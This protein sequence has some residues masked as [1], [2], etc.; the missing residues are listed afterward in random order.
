MQAGADLVPVNVV[1]V[2]IVIGPELVQTGS[3]G[4]DIQ[5][6]ARRGHELDA[7]TCDGERRK[8]RH[9][10]TDERKFFSRS[11]SKFCRSR[12]HS[13]DATR[14]DDVTFGGSG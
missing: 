6:R 1:D 10:R 2:H 11:D 9:R 4:I 14:R 13:Y 12:E 8:R 3:E 5:A 7:A